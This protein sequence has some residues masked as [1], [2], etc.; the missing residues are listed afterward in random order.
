[1]K[2]IELDKRYEKD[3]GAPGERWTGKEVQEFLK[4]QL[5][6]IINQFNSFLIDSPWKLNEDGN[7]QCTLNKDDKEI[8]FTLFP[9]EDS[10]KISWNNGTE[11]GVL[12]WD[13][14]NVA[15][16]KNEGPDSEFNLL[17]PLLSLSNYKEIIP[18]ANDEVGGLMST[19]LYLE[20]K[21]MKEKLDK[22]PDI[23]EEMLKD[24]KGY[25]LCNGKFDDVFPSGSSPLYQPAATAMS[26]ALSSVSNGK[27]MV[28]TDTDP[29]MI[30]EVKELLG[31]ELFN[32]LATKNVQ[33]MEL[34]PVLSPEEKLKQAIAG[35][36]QQKEA[37]ARMTEEMKQTAENVEATKLKDVE[38]KKED[39]Q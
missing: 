2:T 36:Y 33:T 3:W 31:E 14:E 4:S 6:L 28:T 24:G 21:K 17:D 25:V 18:E 23:T 11:E 5:K 19:E 30:E 13:R 8:T 34:Q 16:L 9:S 32:E 29:E 35:Y 20:F 26:L 37:M 15:L 12:I 38:P 7:L 27:L 1:M 10:A 22:Y 39:K